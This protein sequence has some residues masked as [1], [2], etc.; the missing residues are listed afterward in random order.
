MV[1]YIKII[2]KG[3][4]FTGKGLHMKRFKKI[5]AVAA[6][7]LS[8]L[9]TSV[10]AQNIVGTQETAQAATIKLNK[11]NIVLTI[12]KSTKLKVTGTKKKTYWYSGNSAIA[13]VNSKGTVKAI[14]PGSTWVYVNVGNKTLKCKVTVKDFFSEKDAE[15]NTEKKIYENNGTL[16]IILKNNYKYS[17]D[18]KVKC[19]FYDNND[20]PVGTELDSCY[21]IE[22]GKYALLK[23]RCPDNYTSYDIQ[24]EMSKSIYYTEG[25]N[26]LFNDVSI[27]SNMVPE[28]EDDDEK[29]MVTFRNNGSHTIDATAI[30]IYYDRQGKV[31]YAENTSV[32]GLK[33][34]K[35]D[36]TEVD[37]PYESYGEHYKPISYE[38]YETVLSIVENNNW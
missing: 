8:M 24:Y 17:E 5:F 2:D 27:E 35:K 23:L 21:F 15:K 26:S 9:T 14:E 32:Y 37:T 6:L 22:N 34:G 38:R 33:P 20:K 3:A 36:I 18:I 10:A 28:T 31:L 7:S 13:S 25:K 12:G 30:V 29:I 19:Y 1:Q 16:Y 11:K 4:L